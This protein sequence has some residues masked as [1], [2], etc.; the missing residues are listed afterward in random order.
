MADRLSRFEAIVRIAHGF[1]DREV[2]DVT[3]LHPFELREIYPNFPPNVHKLF[4]DGHYAQATFEA[5]KFIDNFVKKHSKNT[6]S[7]YKLMMAAFDKSKPNWIKLTPA[8]TTSESDEQ[9]GYRF[10]FAGAMTGIRNPRGHEALVDDVDTCLD[11]LSFASMLM[12]RLE[13]AGYT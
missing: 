5:F 12:R 9:E 2:V 1:S 7:G 8:V 6:E 4:D 11:H 3:Q 10:I 13:A